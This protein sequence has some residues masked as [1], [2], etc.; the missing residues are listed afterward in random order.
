M[1]K[2]FLFFAAMLVAL[3]VSAT[4]TNISTATTDALR[5]ALDAAASGDTI[6]MAAGTYVESNENYI[7]VKSKSV[8]VMAAEGAEVIV[9]P[10]VCAT[11]SL[12]ARAEFIGIKFDATNL[13]SVKSWYPGVFYIDTIGANKLILEGCELYNSPEYLIKVATKG[14]LD[15]CAINNCFFHDGVNSAIYAEASSSFHPCDHMIITNSTFKD[16]VMTGDVPVVRFENKGKAQASDAELKVDHCT[17]YNYFKTGTAT[18]S[19]IDSRQS[20]NNHISNCIFANPAAIPDGKNKPKASQVYGGTIENC[21]IHNMSNHRT[22]TGI[23]ISNPLKDVDPLFQDAANGDLTLTYGSPALTAATDGGAIGDPR[24]V[25]NFYVTGSAVGGWTAHEKAAVKSYTIKDLAAG[26][27]QM[28]ITRNGTWDGENN[29]Y[30]YDALSAKIGGLYRGTEESNDNICFTLAEAGDVTVTYI[31]GEKFTVEGNFTMPTIELAGSMTEWG[32]NKKTLTPAEDKLTA[33]TTIHLN[34]FYYEF[35]MIVNGAWLSKAGNEGLYT[36]H[37]D[38]NSVSDL[39]DIT[40][41]IV[42]TPDLEGDYTF[43]WT[44]GTGTLTV[45]FPELP[46]PVYYI[47][48]DMTDW[49]NE[50]VAMTEDEG[51]WSVAINLPKA[52][53][54]YAFKVVRVQGPYT[55]WY[56]RDTYN[57][58]NSE[59]STDWGIGAENG[60]SNKQ[61]VGL[62]TA[63]GGNYTFRYIPAASSISVVYPSNP[64]AI[65]NI[66]QEPTANSQK[67]IMNGQLFILRD[68]KTYNVLGATIR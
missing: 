6:V 2:F 16:F 67:L 52:E 37:R 35:K 9:Q 66:S 7:A 11:I 43:T 50:K 32:E 54:E 59:N 44:Y 49:D 29:V 25:P 14:H 21:L 34:D 26:S 39:V 65:G 46:N 20:L 23:T 27:Y 30:G 60:D 68:G 1:R 8:V 36:L 38:W 31:P 61:A 41:N 18:Y 55:K 48:G 62:V 45:T 10:K 24:W 33:S 13:Q 53:T 51:V 15:S 63:A 40:D 47:A 3:T 5:K 56:G 4:T 57:V 58:M 22:G 42:L 28:K 19:T 64:T 12:G 17:F